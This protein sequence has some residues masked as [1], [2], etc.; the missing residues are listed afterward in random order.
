MDSE[1]GSPAFASGMRGSEKPKKQ[2]LRRIEIE[3]AKNGV[4]VQCDYDRRNS[5]GEQM[6]EP[7]IPAVFTSRQSLH[8][9]IDEELDKAD[10]LK[11]KSEEKKERED[12]SA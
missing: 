4:T 10:V 6:F 1:K 12:E 2:R 7:R 9:L 8:D 5:K 11:G 3:V